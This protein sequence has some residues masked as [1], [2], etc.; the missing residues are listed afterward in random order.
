[1]QYIGLGSSGLK[2]SRLW[3]GAMMFGA[4]TDDA[5]ADRIIGMTRDAGLR[6]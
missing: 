3:L 5:E 4:R 2:V 1:M 6:V